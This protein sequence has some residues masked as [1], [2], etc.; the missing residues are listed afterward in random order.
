MANR[1]NSHD[2]ARDPRLDR[3]AAAL[4]ANLQR[5][6]L[7]QRGRASAAAEPSAAGQQPVE[8]KTGDKD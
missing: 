1:E 5:R 8:G 7:Q 2:E 3:R 4:R 6:K